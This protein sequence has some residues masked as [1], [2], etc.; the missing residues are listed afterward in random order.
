MA[1]HMSEEKRRITE[2]I[3]VQWL[4]AK[5]I[6]ATPFKSDEQEKFGRLFFTFG[7]TRGANWAWEEVERVAVGDDE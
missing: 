2:V 3:D 5:R 1:E 7:F 4:K 6:L